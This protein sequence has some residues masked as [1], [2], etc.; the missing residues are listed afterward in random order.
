MSA[1]QEPSIVLSLNI[2]SADAL[3]K[4]LNT[5]MITKGY[6]HGVIA[7]PVMNEINNQYAK[8]QK[9][10]SEKTA[11]PVPPAQTQTAE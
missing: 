11:N 1:N 9:A 7:V 2:E 3:F 4:A 5:A 6:E 8:I 10:Q